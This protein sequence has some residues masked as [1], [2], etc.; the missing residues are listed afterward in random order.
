MGLV[1]IV[2]STVRADPKREVPDYDGRGNVD[3]KA[4]R[5]LWIPRIALLPL[6]VVNESLLRRP[7]GT[8]RVSGVLRGQVGTAAVSSFFAVAHLGSSLVRP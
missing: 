5:W 1:I 4:D 3:A 8:L 2:T 7:V 6:Y